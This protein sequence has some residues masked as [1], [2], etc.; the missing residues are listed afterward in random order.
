MLKPFDWG[1]LGALVNDEHTFSGNN[2]GPVG[3]ETT[4]QPIIHYNF[5]VLIRSE[6]CLRHTEEMNDQFE[7]GESLC[8]D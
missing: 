6:T 3:Q 4:V 5:K 2:S 7:Q 8:I 1:L